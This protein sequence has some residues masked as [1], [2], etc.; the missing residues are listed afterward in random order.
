MDRWAYERNTAAARNDGRVKFCDDRPVL[1]TTM[2]EFVNSTL[3]ALIEKAR[4]APDAK[5]F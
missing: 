3:G 4:K 5:P 1:S 2:G